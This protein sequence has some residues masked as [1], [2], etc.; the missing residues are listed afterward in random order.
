VERKIISD[1]A[2]KISDKVVESSCGCIRNFDEDVK[3]IIR[4]AI[5]KLYLDLEEEISMLKKELEESEK[6]VV[7]W[8]E[9]CMKTSRNSS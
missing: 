4:E 9:E 8:R 2:F 1:L 6:N 7:W 5:L 3:P